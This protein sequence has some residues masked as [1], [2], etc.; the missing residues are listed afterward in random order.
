MIHACVCFVSFAQQYVKPGFCCHW[1]QE[2][3]SLHFSLL[4]PVSSRFCS[5]QLRVL[6][7]QQFDVSK[8]SL[9]SAGI[10]IFFLFFLSPLF[11]LLSFIQLSQSHWLLSSGGWH[12]Y[13][14]PQ[15]EGV[16][17]PESCG[18]S[19]S[20]ACHPPPP[21]FSL[22]LALQLCPCENS[23]ITQPFS[24]VIWGSLEREELPL[25]VHLGRQK[26]LEL[27]SL[28]SAANKAWPCEWRQSL[29]SVLW[30]IPLV[31]RR[32][33]KRWDEGREKAEKLSVMGVFA[34]AEIDKAFSRPSETWITSLFS[35]KSSNWF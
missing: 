10:W 35:P 15:G 7:L 22:S 30:L 31:C 29:F 26:G 12:C 5:S 2:P 16:P 33:E 32:A 14:S 3:A 6:V 9:L 4:S 25:R 18:S 20:F 27:Y 34:K 24:E 28:G 13:Y 21:L 17:L 19:Q 1:M 8:S 11:F 23:P